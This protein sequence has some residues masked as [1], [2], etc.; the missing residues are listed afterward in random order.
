MV[1]A[2]QQT[3]LGLARDNLNNALRS[4]AEETMET[5]SIILFVWATMTLV[6]EKQADLVIRIVKRGVLEVAPGV[7]TPLAAGEMARYLLA[8]RPPST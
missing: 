1:G 7:V 2:W 6:A 3:V 4:V 8:H 5:G